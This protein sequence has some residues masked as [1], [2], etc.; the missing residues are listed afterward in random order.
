MGSTI[1]GVLYYLTAAYVGA[2]RALARDQGKPVPSPH[3]FGRLL[4][5]EIPVLSR[6]IGGWRVVSLSL[7]FFLFVLAAE[8]ALTEITPGPVLTPRWRVVVALVATILLVAGWAVAHAIRSAGWRPPSRKELA[9][10]SA[11]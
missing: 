10:R 11:D 9:S 3:S 7:L 5:E 6:R 1:R 8:I 2:R 4:A